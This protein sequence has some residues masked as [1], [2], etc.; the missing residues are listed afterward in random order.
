MM[1]CE[2]VWQR[3][4]PSQSQTQGSKFFLEFVPPEPGG[5]GGAG[6]H[7]FC[8]APLP[9]PPH[10][11]GVVD[12][13]VRARAASRQIPVVCGQGVIGAGRGGWVNIFLLMAVQLPDTFFLRGLLNQQEVGKNKFNTNL[14][15]DLLD[16]WRLSFCLAIFS[17]ISFY[18]APST[19]PGPFGQHH[20]GDADPRWVGQGRGR[21]GGSSHTHLKLANL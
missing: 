2:Y 18:F 10:P 21:G 16:F 11:G 7:L 13:H 3:S 17:G 14:K 1:M 20:P 19:P 15:L 4:P 8:V 6:G 5:S 12:R 9:H